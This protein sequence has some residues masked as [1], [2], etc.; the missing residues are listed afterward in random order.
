MKVYLSGKI[1]GLKE[2][3]YKANFSKA[4]IE[5]YQ[6][7]NLNVSFK[8]IINPTEIIPLFGIIKYW[9]YII[10]DIIKLLKCDTIYMQDN[11]KDSKGAK[12]ELAIA[13]LT[14][15]KILFQ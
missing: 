5:I 8:N 10:A 11:L 3:E 4:C 6:N 12:I 1:K 15:K 7:D 9:C 2:S 14:G 13:I